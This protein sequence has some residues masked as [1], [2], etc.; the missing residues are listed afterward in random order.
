MRWICVLWNELAEVVAT[1][2]AESEDHAY[3]WANGVEAAF[4]VLEAQG[5]P[6]RAERW[7]VFDA[8]FVQFNIMPAF[9]QEAVREEL[10]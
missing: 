1:E 3:A 7:L 9:V 4:H 8:R 6:R 2:F 5:Q 10:S